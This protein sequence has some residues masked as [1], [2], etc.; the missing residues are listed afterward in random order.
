LGIILGYKFFSKTFLSKDTLNKLTKTCGSK[1][2]PLEN[3]EIYVEIDTNYNDTLIREQGWFTYD[4]L[5]Q[6]KQ[7]LG[8]TIYDFLEDEQI[9]EHYL[10]GYIK[11]GDTVGIITPDSLLHTKIS[12]HKTIL[13]KWIV[14]PI[15]TNE[16]L[17]IKQSNQN[18]QLVFNIELRNLHGQLVKQEKNIQTSH[19]ALNIADLKAGV[20][21]YVIKENEG[22][23][24]QGKLI[25]K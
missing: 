3:Y 24:Q 16:W 11:N 13:K 18:S 7:G 23:V 21:F 14:Y 2:A 8:R 5:V 19:F 15:P 4:V 25:V 12:D 17:Y 9:L 6:Y 10:E 1:Y 22:V 20:Y